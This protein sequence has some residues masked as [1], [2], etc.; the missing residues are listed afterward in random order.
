MARKY[1]SLLLLSSA[2]ILAM[3]AAANAQE[4]EQVVVSASRISIVGY[5]AST[6]VTVLDSAALN[7]DAKV[8]IGDSLRELPAVGIS[9]SLSNAARNA[10]SGPGDALLDTVSL[11]S[12]GTARTLVLLDGQRVVTSNPSNGSAGGGG[13]AIGT[14]G[15]GGVDLSTLP[16]S[17]IQRVDVV[18]GGASAAWGSDAVAGVVNLVLNK[19]FE[20][21]KANAEF[22]DT[23]KNDHRVYKMELTAGTGFA[24]DRGH[25][26]LSAQHTMSPDA[27]F[28][29]Q[30]SWWRPQ[31]LFPAGQSPTQSFASCGGGT[32]A[33]PECIRTYI[34]GGTANTIGGLI[35]SSAAGVG[36]V[37]VNGVTALAPANALKGLQF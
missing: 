29:N 30:R 15:G 4:P 33:S 22:G 25:L 37:G 5:Q 3:F 28:I 23:D 36:T 8:N 27:V 31:G 11:R 34:N 12:L 35:T 32:V 10:N 20:G 26:I 2:S 19:N 24:G 6:P 13:G 17:L 14:G 7:R 1:S 21:L 18:T 9:D 16:T